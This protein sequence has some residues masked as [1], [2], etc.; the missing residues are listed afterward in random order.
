M[1]PVTIIV[2]IISDVNVLN[3]IPLREYIESLL[4]SHIFNSVWVCFQKQGNMYGN[5]FIARSKDN[6]YDIFERVD[7]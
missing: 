2:D 4:I 7:R 3:S 5:T 1:K 6:I